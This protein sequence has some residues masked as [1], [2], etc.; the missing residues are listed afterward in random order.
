MTEDEPFKG[1][2]EIEL[3]RVSLKGPNVFSTLDAPPSPDALKA[4][5]DAVRRHLKRGRQG[6]DRPDA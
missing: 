5:Q 6:S 1:D 4:Q 3:T 2:E